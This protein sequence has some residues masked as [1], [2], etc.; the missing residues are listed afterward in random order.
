MEQ[1][2]DILTKK[3]FA[4]LAAELDRQ[5]HKLTGALVQSF[6]YKIKETA[7]S[8]TIQFLMNNYGVFLNDGVP[9]NRIPYTP[10]PPVRG[11]TSKYIQGLI[12]WAKLKFRYDEKRARSMAFAV[13]R[14]HK[15]FGFPLTQRGFI[16]NTL[17]QEEETIERFVEDYIEIA[18]EEFFKSFLEDNK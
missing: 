17:K 14:K 2:I 15:Q 10:P 3:I 7:E 4:A 1:L 11:G 12:R 18:F 8:T 9:P 13:A 5:N 16:N 6:E